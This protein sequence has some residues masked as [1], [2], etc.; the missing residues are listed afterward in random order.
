MRDY[1]SIRRS[2]CCLRSGGLR[3]RKSAGDLYTSP[4]PSSVISRRASTRSLCVSVQKND[5]AA[6]EE[7]ISL[8][9]CLKPTRACASLRGIAKMKSTS[10]S[11]QLLHVARSRRLECAASDPCNHI[12][13]LPCLGQPIFLLLKGLYFDDFNSPYF[14]HPR[15]WAS[16]PSPQWLLL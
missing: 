6:V 13:Y 9:S 15:I 11:S 14:G 3:E 5:K 7:G 2:R 10:A 4:L 8:L 16:S 12:H 1:R